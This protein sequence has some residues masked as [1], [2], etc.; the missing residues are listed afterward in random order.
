VFEKLLYDRLYSYLEHNKLSTDCQYGFRKGLSTEL[1]IN[2]LQ[3][4][5]TQNIDKGLLTCS[6]FLDLAKAFD[7]VNHD[8]LLH[9][10]DIQYGIKDLPLSLLKNYLE[11]RSHYVVINDDS[12]SEMAKFTCGVP[13][14]ST[15]GPLL[16]LLYANDLPLVSN[17]K[18]ILFA[19]DMVLSLS[20]NSMHELT[21]KINHELETVDNWLKYNK[22]SLNYSKTQF[23]LFTKQNEYIDTNF[24]VQINNHLLSRT[25]CVKYLGVI[26]DDKL[27]WKHHITLV[28]K[29]SF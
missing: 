12:R 7:T 17:F 27:I 8:I 4:F 26:I 20:A 28:K 3:N 18:T 19:D 15:L 6:I 1:A 21:T 25:E 24:N 16:F 14:G 9:K 23:M 2:D 5:L 10:L 22:L 11:N 29:T 13:Q